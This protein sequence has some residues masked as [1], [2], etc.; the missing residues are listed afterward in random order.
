M[1]QKVRSELSSTSLGLQG[2]LEELVCSVSVLTPW[3]MQILS[4]ALYSLQ[5]NDAGVSEL[6]G[7]TG[8]QRRMTEIGMAD[9]QIKIK[10][11]PQLSELS[12]F[13]GS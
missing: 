8:M 11:A 6:T 13:I 7:T 3:W 4:R 12:T 1:A 2:E 5:Q 10:I 9:S